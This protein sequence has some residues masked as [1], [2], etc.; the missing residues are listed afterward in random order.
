M[1]P[2]TLD[3]KID[4]LTNVVEKMGIQMEKG[5]AAIAEDIADIRANMATKGDVRAIVREETAEIR[6]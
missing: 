1:Q 2:K 6:K 3:Q 4:S 5:F